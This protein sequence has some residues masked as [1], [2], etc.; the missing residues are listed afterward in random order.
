M[1]KRR[2][3]NETPPTPVTA[4]PTPTINCLQ[5]L[6]A[7]VNQSWY[8]LCFR[9]VNF[10]KIVIC[11]NLSST[12]DFTIP[13]C[14]WIRVINENKGSCTKYFQYWLHS[15]KCKTKKKSHYEWENI[16]EKGNESVLSR[17]FA[18]KEEKNYGK[19]RVHSSPLTTHTNR[20]FTFCSN[21]CFHFVYGKFVSI[22][23]FA[24]SFLWL[25]FKSYRYWF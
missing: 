3:E 9:F 8:V 21:I 19:Y 23:L 22:F 20:K 25:K 15:R 24:D 1:K 10:H 16:L 14:C 18:E 12:I 7:N 17:T 11:W 6:S 5:V 4:T 13:I 2:T